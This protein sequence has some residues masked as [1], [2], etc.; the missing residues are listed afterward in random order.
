MGEAPAGTITHKQ[1]LFLALPLILATISTPLLGAVDTAVVGFLDDPAYIGGVA[2]GTLIFNTL[3]WLFGFLRVSTSGY[4]AQAVGAGDEGAV[5]LNFLRAAFLATS[6]GL[7]FLVLQLP[8]WDLAMYVIQP[9]ANVMDQGSKYFDVRIWGAPFTLLNYVILGWLIGKAK[10]RVVLLLQLGC[11]LL[12]MGLNVYFVYSVQMG[13]A[14]VGLATLIAEVLATVI[15]L[16]FM[17]KYITLDPSIIKSKSILA[18]QPMIHMVKVNQDLFIR[19]ACLLAVFGIFTSTGASMGEVIIAANAILF[20]LHFIMAYFFDGLANASSILAGKA[21]GAN[22]K[23]LFRCTIYLGCFW[24][25]ALAFLL[26]VMMFVGGSWLISLF[27]NIEEVYSTAVSYEWWVTLFPITGFLGLQLYGF[28]T[29]ATQ[30]GPVRDSLLISLLIF[31]I[32]VWLTVPAWGNHGLWFSFILF[33]ML[34]SL[35]LWAFFSKLQRTV[36][37]HSSRCSRQNG[38]N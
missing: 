14:G 26:T 22:D 8:I 20:Q 27:T 2:V 16:L 4:T 33:T 35:T 13:I 38:S 19:T 11:N 6:V 12:N 10:V 23:K 24:S 30:A 25:A 17:M 28:Y 32:S 31:V 9:S 21:V 7:L 18:F 5:L 29:G 1:Y 3:Y 37:W 36:F 34:R 15:G